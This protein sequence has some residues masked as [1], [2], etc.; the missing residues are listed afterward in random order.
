MHA[1]A[2][3]CRAALYSMDIIF[4][5]ARPV[6]STRRRLVEVFWSLLGSNANA[7]ESKRPL[8]VASPER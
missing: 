1:F 6:M 8:V 4:I 7:F 2:Y 5:F 3:S